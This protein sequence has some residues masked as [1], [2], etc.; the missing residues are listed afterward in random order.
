VE[1]TRR[2]LAHCAVHAEMRL[3]DV[4]CGKG[5]SLAYAA[6]LGMQ[7]I[8]LDLTSAML[9]QSRESA[10]HAPLIQAD[11]LHLPLANQ[12]I[13][14]VLA[15]C[16]LSLVADHSAVLGEIGRVLRPGGL[17]AVSDVYLRHGQCAATV[18]PML[19]PAWRGLAVSRAM[20]LERLAAADFSL[21]HWEDQPT[22]LHQF[23]GCVPPATVAV[24]WEA[25]EG[26]E[27]FTLALAVARAKPGYFL[28]MARRNGHPPTSC[29]GRTR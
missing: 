12:V 14:L 4:G 20:L 13:D 1:L 29:T 16:S 5:A 24:H 17:L 23:S 7:A 22:A 15:E 6:T 26:V 21:I 28:L 27:P 2:A 9:Q 19:A 25:D 18:A 10:P 8:G 3:L 11:G